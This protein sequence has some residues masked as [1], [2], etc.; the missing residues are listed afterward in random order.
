[1]QNLLRW[2]YPNLRLATEAISNY[3]DFWVT[4]SIQTNFAC[5]ELYSWYPLLLYFL[6]LLYFIIISPYYVGEVVY[7][8]ISTYVI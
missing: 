4:S 2:D 7:K 8:R 5:L 1:M 3:L 6:S